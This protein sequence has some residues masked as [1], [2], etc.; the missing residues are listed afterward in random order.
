[1]RSA[2][3]DDSVDHGVLVT[4]G[5]RTRRAILDAALRVVAAGGVEAMTHRSVATEAGIAHGTITYHFRSRDDIILA[6]FRHHIERVSTEL[7]ALFEERL[8]TKWT[9]DEFVVEFLRRSLQDRQSLVAE[10]E[11]I[12]YASRD[13]ELAAEYRRWQRLLERQAAEVLEG[14]GATRPHEA[15]RVVVAL[16]RAFELSCLTDR[17]RRPEELGEQLTLVLPALLG[18]AT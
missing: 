18:T 8:T 2:I 9:I 13:A 4:R 15:A 17:E 11:L 5:E 1:M 7:D 16:T 3:A 6:A 12:L 14:D 10:Y